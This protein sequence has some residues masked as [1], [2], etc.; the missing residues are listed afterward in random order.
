MSVVSQRQ[1]WSFY[2]MYI[3]SGFGVIAGISGLGEVQ[4]SA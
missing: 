1:P 2:L 3:I 4:D